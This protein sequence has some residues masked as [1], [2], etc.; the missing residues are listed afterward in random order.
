MT[1]VK[2]DA[3]RLSA[4]MSLKVQRI[5]AYGFEDM[6]DSTST[7]GLELLQSYQDEG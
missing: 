6:C 2:N 1:F 3:G 5:T 7:V 4:G